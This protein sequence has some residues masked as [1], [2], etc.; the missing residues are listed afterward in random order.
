MLMC[1]P[2]SMSSCVTA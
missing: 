2:S 1:F